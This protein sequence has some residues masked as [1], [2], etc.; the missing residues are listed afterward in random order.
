MPSP[1]YV[2]ARPS[3]TENGPIIILQGRHPVVE[4]HL[5]ELRTAGYGGL[6]L[7]AST[8]VPNDL[9]LG[10]SANLQVLTGPNCSGKL[11]LSI[12]EMLPIVS[13]SRFVHDT[14]PLSK[15]LLFTQAS[16]LT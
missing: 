5:R 9:Y 2:A 16:L 14:L 8:Y 7:P 4:Q 11:L 15:R 12:M 13:G 10:A 6:G 3:F 1:N